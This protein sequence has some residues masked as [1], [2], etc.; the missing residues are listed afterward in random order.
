MR[1]LDFAALGLFG[2]A[3]TAVTIGFSSPAPFLAAGGD[4]GVPLA[5]MIG[6]PPGASRLAGIRFGAPAGE[7]HD[8]AVAAVPRG[9]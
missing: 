2:I 4:V 5:E 3:L 8:P 1:A 7:T 9:F 6:E